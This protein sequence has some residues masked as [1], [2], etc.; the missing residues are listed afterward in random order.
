MGR[1][2]STFVTSQQRSVLVCYI[3]IN[4]QLNYLYNSNEINEEL[5][6]LSSRQSDEHDDQADEEESGVET[7][8]AC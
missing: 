6:V 7:H 5:T 3:V 2:E 4:M 8:L 1:S